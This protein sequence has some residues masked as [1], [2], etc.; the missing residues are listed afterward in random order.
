MFVDI[1]FFN[2]NCYFAGKFSFWMSNDANT[3][4]VRSLDFEDFCDFLCA[5]LMPYYDGKSKRRYELSREHVKGDT[6]KGSRQ[7]NEPFRRPNVLGNGYRSPKLLRRIKIFQIWT[8]VQ[9]YTHEYRKKKSQRTF[10]GI[11]FKLH[12]WKITY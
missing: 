5:Q 2:V 4:V 6:W 1:F 7:Q 10:V 11:W 3:I 9:E 12:K 8:K